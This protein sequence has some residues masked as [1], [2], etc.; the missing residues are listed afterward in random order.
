MNDEN[1]IDLSIEMYEDLKETLVKAIKN[2]KA[3]KQGDTR[4]DD[5]QIE[6]IERLIEAAERSQWQVAQLLEQLQRHTALPGVQSQREQAIADKYNSLLKQL[7]GRLEII[8]KDNRQTYAMM[9]QMKQTVEESAKPENLPV[10]EHHH[11]YTFDIKSSKTVLVMFVMAVMIVLLTGF[12]YQVSVSNQ[13]LAANDLKYRYVKMCG[14]IGEKKLTELETVFRDEQHKAIRDTVQNQVE[15]YETRVRIRAEQLEGVDWFLEEILIQLDP[16]MPVLSVTKG[17]RATDDG[18]LLSYPGYWMSELAKR[19]IH[20][21]ICAVGGPCTSYELVFKDPTEVAFCGWDNEVLRMMKQA[22]Q[23]PYYHISLTNDVIGL[24]SAV[25]LKNAY[26]MAVT[27]AVGLNIRWHGEEEVQHFNSQAG[28]FTQAVRETHALMLLQGGEF[29][30]ECIGLG[31]LYVTIFSG[32][33]RRCGV[34]MGRGLNYNQVTEA[35]AGIT[36][37][38]LVITRIMGNAIRRKAELGLVNLEDF[39]LLMHIVDILDHGK[40][41]SDMPWESFV[42]EHLS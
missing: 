34:L 29:E 40:A 27:L 5:T 30:S 3:G 18:S 23:R 2:A 39:P 41:D 33:T 1:R 11:T 4:L 9:E 25:A 31:D 13:Q 16:E 32:R 7:A 28:T 24:E 26:A 42:F 10:Q 14:G 36:L 38:S 6:R 35:L 21:D 17:L 8:D 20:R 19:G 12:I 22:M 15:R 37:E